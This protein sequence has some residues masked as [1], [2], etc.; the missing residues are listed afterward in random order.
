MS[1][2]LWL[3]CFA[4][5]C[6]LLARKAW[7]YT[8]RNQPRYIQIGTERC[9]RECGNMDYDWCYRARYLEHDVKIQVSERLGELWS[10][11][12]IVVVDN[13]YGEIGRYFELPDAI[14]AACEHVENREAAK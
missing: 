5:A 7:T 4:G 14:R 3:W 6:L 9:T 12:T 11:Y 8:H 13:G 10:K 1:G 2:R